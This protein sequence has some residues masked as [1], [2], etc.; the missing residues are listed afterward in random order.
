VSGN[1]VL[2]GGPGNDLLDGFDGDDIA[3]G[4]DGNEFVADCGSATTASST[5]GRATTS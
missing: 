3:R 1:D 2:D 5:A 4:G